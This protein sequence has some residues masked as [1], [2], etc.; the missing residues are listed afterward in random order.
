MPWSAR[1]LEPVFLPDG[2]RLETLHD[3]AQ[4]ITELPKAE[5]DNAEW[6]HAMATLLLVAEHDGPSMMAHI[7]MMR[8]LHLNRPKPKPMPRKKRAKAH[9]IV[10]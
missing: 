7:A 2:R 5:H 8:A 1:F 6:Q 10:R 4:Y 9:R 3:A